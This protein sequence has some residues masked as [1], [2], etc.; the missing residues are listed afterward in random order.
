MDAIKQLREQEQAAWNALTAHIDY[1][2]KCKRREYT[3]RKA[4]SPEPVPDVEFEFRARYRAWEQARE[5]L[6]SAIRS[7][8]Y[9]ANPPVV[10]GNRPHPS[11]SSP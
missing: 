1:T 11:R 5:A 8:A 7:R 3:G 9:S 6:Q 10:S 4:Y 2:D